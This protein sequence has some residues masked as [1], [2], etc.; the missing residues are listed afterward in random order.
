MDK[1]LGVSK[2]FPDTLWRYVKPSW[3][4]SSGSLLPYCFDLRSEPPEEYVSFFEG[5]G[6]T[7]QQM[8]SSVIGALALSRFVLKETGRIL[9]IDPQHACRLINCPVPIIEFKDQ[10]R[11][12]FG[13]F[14]LIEDE[15]SRLEAKNILSQIVSLHGLKGRV[16]T[17]RGIAALPS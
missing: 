3:L 12:H 15:P 8:L 1:K 5:Q 9:S 16:C 17:N 11:P 7:E 13:M 10:R 6:E 14:Y 2:A 4:D